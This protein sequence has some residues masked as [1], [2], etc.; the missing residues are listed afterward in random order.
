ML[1]KGDKLFEQYLSELL[2][3]IIDTKNHDKYDKFKL[4]KAATVQGIENS[5]IKINNKYYE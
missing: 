1:V 2:I 5:K 3:N 4:M